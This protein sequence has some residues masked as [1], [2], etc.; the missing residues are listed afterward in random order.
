LRL[1]AR[2]V[3]PSIVMDW[4]R[5]LWVLGRRTLILQKLVSS[6]S[7]SKSIVHQ[8]MR[9]VGVALAKVGWPLTAEETYV[10]LV[11]VHGGKVWGRRVNECRR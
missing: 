11:G 1:A 4:W 2:V 9:A 7:S 5:L 8:K 10:L 6:W 3:R